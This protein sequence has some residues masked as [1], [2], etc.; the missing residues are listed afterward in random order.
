[1]HAIVCE[2]TNVTGLW[3]IVYAR[4]ADASRTGFMVDPSL[5]FDVHNRHVIS[6]SSTQFPI[7]TT[8]YQI[9]IFVSVF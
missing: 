5:A 7:P 8:Q 4:P 2:A 9:P 3:F 1:M 6:L